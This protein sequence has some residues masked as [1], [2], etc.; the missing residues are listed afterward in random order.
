MADCD[1]ESLAAVLEE[2]ILKPFVGDMRQANKA[3]IQKTMKQMV[4]ETKAAKFDHAYPS[5]RPHG[6]YQSHIAHTGEPVG[7]DG[8]KETWHVRAPEHRLT[9]LLADGH[10]TVDGKRTKANPFLR[11]ARDNADRNVLKNIEEEMT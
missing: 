10:A 4:K 7:T 9:H 3:G 5:A 8:W 2:E 6:T 1:V 11:D